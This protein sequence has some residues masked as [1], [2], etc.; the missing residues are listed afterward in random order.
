MGATVAACAS[1]ATSTPQRSTSSSGGPAPTGSNAADAAAP[2][3]D[4]AVDEGGRPLPG[5]DAGEEP[6]DA[7]P[8]PGCPVVGYDAGGP[9]AS[10]AIGTLTYIAAAG[11]YV[12]RDA[13]GLYGM[14]ALC[15]HSV[16]NLRIDPTQLVCLVHGAR[17]SLTGAVLQGPANTPLPHFA[18]CLNAKGN[19]A[20][21]T[22]VI[23]PATT[24]LVA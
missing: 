23:V 9:P 7:A 15:T 21:D 1:E 14:Y 6:V 4:A 17:F 20:V 3:A 22:K 10:F 19:V 24:R 12:G 8:S 13:G 5:L 11:A 18:I 16:G 2:G